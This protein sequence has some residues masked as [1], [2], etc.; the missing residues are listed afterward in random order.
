MASDNLLKE[1]PFSF[2]FILVLLYLVLLT[3]IKKIGVCRE[4]RR[5]FFSRDDIGEENHGTEAFIQ[6]QVG[7]VEVKPR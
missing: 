4:E 6:V 7:L 5:V 2:P 3:V 1:I